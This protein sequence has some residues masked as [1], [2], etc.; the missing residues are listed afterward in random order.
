MSLAAMRTTTKIEEEMSKKER[1]IISLLLVVIF[2]FVSFDLL[3]DSREGAAS[4]HLIFEGAVA[5]AAAF[6]IGV[7]VKDSFV[8][9][10]ILAQERVDFAE[11]K[12]EASKW[13]QQAKKYS[14]G[15]SQAIDEQLTKWALTNSEKEVAFLLIKGLSLKEIAELRQTTEKTARAQSAAIYSKAGLNGRS[16]LAAFFLEDLLV[17]TVLK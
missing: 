4:W 1:A 6:A 3:T 5:L 2:M 11:F 8:A 14:E 9:K 13:R 7:L 17:P 15:L 10:N 12:I 16:E